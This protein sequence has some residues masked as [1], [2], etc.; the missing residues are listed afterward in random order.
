MSDLM[1][2]ASAIYQQQPGGPLVTAGL[3]ANALTNSALQNQ[4]ASAQAQYAPYSQY[5]DI[6]SKMMSPALQLMSNPLLWMSMQ[7]NPNGAQD[8]LNKFSSYLPNMGQ[9][10]GLNIPAPGQQQNNNPFSNS[11]MGR[12]IN[13]LEGKISGDPNNNS[14]NTSSNALSNISTDTLSNQNAFS[15][16]PSTSNGNNAPYVNSGAALVPSSSNALNGVVAK[17]TAPYTEEPHTPGLSFSTPQG[18]IISSPTMPARTQAQESIAAINRVSPL[19]DQLT[20]KAEP[21]F[22][23]GDMG[24]VGLEGA[25]NFL[26]GTNYPLPSQYRSFQTNTTLPAEGLIRS[27]GLN[28]TDTNVALMRGVI[29]PSLGES[30]STYKQRILDTLENIRQEQLG[31]NK[32]ILANGINVTPTQ[33]EQNN[34]NSSASMNGNNSISDG[35]KALA[36]NLKLPSFNSAAD[37]QAWFKK[38]DPMVQQAVRLSLGG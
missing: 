13:Y 6:Y 30:Q 1:P 5:A 31:Q 20:Q 38:Q 33:S 29:V 2:S 32:N 14:S 19:I 27:Y 17:M 3:G 11:L 28:P 22:T 15:Q 10:G 7:N 36:K 23:I 18:Q 25:S 16:I 4:I 37:Y 12:T 21:F 34:S 9:R 35:A 8:L 24:K 26:T